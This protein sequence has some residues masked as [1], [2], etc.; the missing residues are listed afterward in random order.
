VYLPHC[1]I[2]NCNVTGRYVVAK[3]GLLLSGSDNLRVFEDV[4]LRWMFGSKR[5][6]VAG[7]CRNLN[8]RGL[9]SLT[10]GQNIVRVMTSRRTMG[11]GH[12]LCLV[13]RGEG[14]GVGGKKH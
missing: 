11:A 10:C 9:H 4:V 6:G 8:S 2:R 14:H 12:V 5:D 7:E 3:F 13:E 1:I